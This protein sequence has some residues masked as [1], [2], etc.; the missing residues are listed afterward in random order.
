[1][2][3]RRRR[4]LTA[5]E[6]RQRTEAGRK[7]RTDATTP[8]G[9]LSFAVG[10]QSQPGAQDGQVR[11]LVANGIPQTPEGAAL[12]ALANAHPPAESDEHGSIVGNMLA[13]VRAR[14]IE[15]AQEARRRRGA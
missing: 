7:S 10:H 2:T 12:M 8:T 1:M 11:I 3:D 6:I 13:S 15:R 9:V 4:Q 14:S 5:D